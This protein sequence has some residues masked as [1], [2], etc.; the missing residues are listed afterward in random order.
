MQGR[1][2]INGPIPAKRGFSPTERKAD[3]GG[4]SKDLD[5]LAIY[6]NSFEVETLSPY[7]EGPGKLSEKA[8]RGKSIL[9]A[10][11]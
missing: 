2:L 1:G 8:Q 4:R 9:K 6:S 10:P 5:A 7:S 3:L 11:P